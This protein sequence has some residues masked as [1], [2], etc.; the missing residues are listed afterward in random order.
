M[1]KN[2]HHLTILQD[3]KKTD[4]DNNASNNNTA[5]NI[6]NETTVKKSDSNEST[7]KPGKY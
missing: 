2:I 1:P 4:V 3:S 5:K 6:L 7:K